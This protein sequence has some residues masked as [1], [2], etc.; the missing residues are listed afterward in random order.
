[1]GLR[2]YNSPG[3]IIAAAVITE[4]LAVS[5]VGL[6]FYSRRW[7]RQKITTSDWLIL[8]ALVIGTGLAV[9]EIYGKHQHTLSS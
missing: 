5:C 6:R 3:G 2:M 9:M 7:K 8:V 1:M 4:V